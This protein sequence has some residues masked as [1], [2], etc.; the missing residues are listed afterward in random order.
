MITRNT[1]KDKTP[2][3][4]WEQIEIQGGAHDGHY[5]NVMTNENRLTLSDGPRKFTYWRSPNGRPVF[6]AESLLK[7]GR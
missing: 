1:E 3:E 2:P 4:G 7:G 5:F 6:V